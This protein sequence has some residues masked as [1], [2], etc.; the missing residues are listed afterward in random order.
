LKLTTKILAR[1]LL[2]YSKIKMMSLICIF[3]THNN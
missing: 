2:N 3:S 1:K